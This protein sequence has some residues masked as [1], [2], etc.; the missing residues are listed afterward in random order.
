MAILP[1]EPTQVK[2]SDLRNANAQCSFDRLYLKLCCG[3]SVG[4]L[5]YSYLS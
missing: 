2:E 5:C 3:D 1:S 4:W